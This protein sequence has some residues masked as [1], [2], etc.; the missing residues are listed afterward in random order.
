MDAL[1]LRFRLHRKHLEQFE[2]LS[3]KSMDLI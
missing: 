2:Q 1:G 3:C